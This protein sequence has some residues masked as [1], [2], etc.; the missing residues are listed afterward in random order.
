MAG[1]VASS[2]TLAVTAVCVHMA[3]GI[4]LVICPRVFELVDTH[5]PR[6]ERLL[7]KYV[8]QTLSDI[9]CSNT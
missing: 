8:T 3:G 1:S 4:K 6:P 5:D 7:R 2:A 9:L